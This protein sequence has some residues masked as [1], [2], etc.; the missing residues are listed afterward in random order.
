[1]M[2]WAAGGVGMPHGSPSQYLAFPHVPISQLQPGDLVFFGVRP[3][4]HHV[5][6]RTSA[7][8]R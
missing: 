5:G 3:S 6:H 7:A 2:A 4:N 1:M 8:A